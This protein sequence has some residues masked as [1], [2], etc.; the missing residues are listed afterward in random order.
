MAASLVRNFCGNAQFPQIFRK[1]PENLL[2]LYV[3][4]KLPHQEIRQNFGIL[5]S[6]GTIFLG[7][8]RRGVLL[9]LM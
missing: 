6:G 5:R 9:Q 1:L 3:S 8:K 4:K 7:S 2:K